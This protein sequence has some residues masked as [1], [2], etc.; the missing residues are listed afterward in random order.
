MLYTKLLKAAY[1][2]IKAV[3]RNATVITAGLS[4]ACTCDGSM[5]AQD[6]LSGI[7]AAG[8]RGYFDAVGMHPYTYPALPT[9]TDGSAYWWTAMQDLRVIMAQNGDAAKLIWATEYGAPTNGPPGSGAVSEAVQA[10]M[11]TQSY[12]LARA[13]TWMGPLFWYCLNDPGT[14]SST[15][16]TFFGLLRFNKT[17]KPAYNSLKAAPAV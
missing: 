8:G 7:Y 12:Q 4:P 14:D 6:F 2:A 3:D 9:A 15:V 11:L 10:T 1:T 16:E 13:A 5:R 17:K